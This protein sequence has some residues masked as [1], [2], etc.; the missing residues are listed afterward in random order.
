MG[1]RGLLG[2]RKMGGREGQSRVLKR[3]LSASNKEATLVLSQ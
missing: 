3:M 2:G 1:L